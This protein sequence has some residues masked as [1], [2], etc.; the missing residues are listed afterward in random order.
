M[1]VFVWFCIH[2]LTPNTECASPPLSSSTQAL[3]NVQELKVNI[4]NSNAELNQLRQAD[5]AARD[6]IQTLR[7]QLKAKSDES[8]DQAAT[9]K[10]K[11]PSSAAPS[12]QRQPQAVQ[13]AVP[14]V[15]PRTA[16][17]T[18]KASHPDG[19]E[20]GRARRPGKPPAGPVVLSSTSTDPKKLSLIQQRA[21]RLTSQSSAAGAVHTVR[22]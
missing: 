3:N 4:Q 7:A 15:K 12:A 6:E 16:A 22:W 9:T 17:V 20:N 14:Q 18:I 2:L 5:V 21:Q 10:H 8:S 19:K 11:Q 1:D 13:R